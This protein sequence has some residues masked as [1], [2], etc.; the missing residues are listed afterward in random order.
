[1][2]VGWVMGVGFLLCDLLLLWGKELFPKTQ[3]CVQTGHGV[4]QA[5]ERAFKLQELEKGL[6][7]VSLGCIDNGKDFPRLHGKREVIDTYC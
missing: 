4:L 3:S 5:R 6:I 1:M 7:L 2:P